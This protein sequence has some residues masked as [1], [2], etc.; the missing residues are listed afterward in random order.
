MPRINKHIKQ[1]EIEHYVSA[2]GALLQ[3]NRTLGVFYVYAAE[4]K[5]TW[6]WVI[7]PYTKERVRRLR[8]LDKMSWYVALDEAIARLKNGA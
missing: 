3:F 4:D 1:E 6:A 8:E 2:A 7:N 5:D